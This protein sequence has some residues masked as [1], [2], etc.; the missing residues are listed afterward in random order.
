MTGN[1]RIPM[2]GSIEINLSRL[3]SISL[4]GTFEIWAYNTTTELLGLVYNG[5]AWAAPDAAVKPGD[6]VDGRRNVTS[7]FEC[8]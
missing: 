7:Q 2:N 1:V 3:Q 8:Q 4:E 5:K 6:Y